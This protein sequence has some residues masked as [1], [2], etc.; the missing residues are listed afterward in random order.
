[1][2]KFGL[3][4]GILLFAILFQLCSSGM[5]FLSLILGFLGIVFV[6]LGFFEKTDDK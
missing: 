2:K 4:F 1:M 5:D 6:I 3:G